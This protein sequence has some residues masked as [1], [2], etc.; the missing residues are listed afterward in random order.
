MM[1]KPS[2]S[3]PAVCD[4]PHRLRPFPF[5]LMGRIRDWLAVSALFATRRA[6]EQLALPDH[7]DG[8]PSARVIPFPLPARAQ[9]LKLAH[10][11]GAGKNDAEGIIPLA[12]L[13]HRLHIDSTAYVDVGNDRLPFRIVLGEGLSTRITVETADFA[14]ARSFIAQYLM[15]T[16]GPAG[17]AS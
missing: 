2:T 14:E 1:R 6:N 5:R 12:G 8:A 17:A 16:R 15:L 4:D 7:D 3:A 10:E 11:L 9:L 13:Q